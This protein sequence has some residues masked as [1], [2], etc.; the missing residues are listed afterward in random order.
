[1]KQTFLFILTVISVRSYS[2]TTTS[3]SLSKRLSQPLTTAAPLLGGVNVSYLVSAPGTDNNTFTMNQ[4]VVDVSTPIYRAMKTKHPLFIKTGLRYQGLYLNG[5]KQIGIDNFHSFTIPVF[6]TYVFNRNTNLTVLA[7]AGVGSDFRGDL[8]AEDIYYTA[9]MRFGFRQSKN[10][11]IGVTLIY[12]KSYAGT[13]LLPLPD[14]DWTISKHWRLEAFIP[15]R[16]SLKY[17]FNEHQTLAFTQGFQTGNFRVHDY[18]GTGKYLQLQGVTTGLMYDHTFN[19]RW[20]IYLIAGMAVSQKLQTFTNDQ[21]LG[22][23]QFSK[24]NDR[25]PTVSYEKGGIVGQAGI[26]YKF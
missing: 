25:I 4:A 19:R 6:M 15:F 14:I 17:K 18:T 21:Q 22:L 2:Q 20:N 23:N 1:M 12:S 11:R 24:M 8:N 10:F 26:N 3:D 16:T 5:E 13:N 9:G 7:N